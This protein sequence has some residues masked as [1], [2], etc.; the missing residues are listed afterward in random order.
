MPVEL[1]N[2]ISES[3]TYTLVRI[4]KFNVDLE[5]KKIV[6]YYKMGYMDGE[7]E[8]LKADT[9]YIAV[10]D[11]PLAEPPSTEFT[12]LMT[13]WAA[14]YVQVKEKL[15]ELLDDKLGFTGTIV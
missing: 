8:V 10:S 1:Q 15:Y 2:E 14:V 6:V 9:E 11:S 13:D 3:K 12:D 5:S 7:N 4:T